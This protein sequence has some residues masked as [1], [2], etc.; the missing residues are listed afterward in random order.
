MS[1]F[2]P[3]SGSTSKTENFFQG[4]GPATSNGSN[5]VGKQEDFSLFG[6]G[7]SP[8]QGCLYFCVYFV[9]FWQQSGKVFCGF[10]GSI[11]PNGG[12]GL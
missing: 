8:T 1:A 12:I 5:R 4:I 9:V 10:F 11:F 2:L 7:K 6:K 3:S